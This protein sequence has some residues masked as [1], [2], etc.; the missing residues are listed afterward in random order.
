MD[1]LRQAVRDPRSKVVVYNRRSGPIAA[2]VT[3]TDNILPTTRRG[4]RALANLLVIYA[5]DRG[6]II[7]GYQFSARDKAG[8]PQEARWL[9]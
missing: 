6:T 2:T 8:I 7:T 1:D 3:P 9:R 4:S 5:V